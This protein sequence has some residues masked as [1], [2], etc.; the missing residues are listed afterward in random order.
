MIYSAILVILNT[1]LVCVN[2]DS[3]LKSKLPP[4]K[5]KFYLG[6]GNIIITIFIIASFYFLS[7]EQ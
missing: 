4:E 3:F 1:T 6:I 7:K 5:S 2:Y